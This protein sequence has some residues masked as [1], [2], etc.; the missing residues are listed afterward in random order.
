MQKMRTVRAK[1]DLSIVVKELAKKHDVDKCNT[2]MIWEYLQNYCEIQFKGDKSFV[3]DAIEKTVKEQY[4]ECFD[5][6]IEMIK[7]IQETT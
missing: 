1:S 2:K 4:E 7:R 6:N 5:G 3:P